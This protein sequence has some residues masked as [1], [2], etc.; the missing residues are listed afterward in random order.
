MMDETYRLDRLPTL[1]QGRLVLD[2]RTAKPCFDGISRS[3]QFLD[4]RLEVRF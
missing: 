2:I 4:L 1:G 3:L